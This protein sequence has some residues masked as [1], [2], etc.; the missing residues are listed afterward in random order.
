MLYRNRREKEIRDME[1]AVNDIDQWAKAKL[2]L[3][4]ARTKAPSLLI[5]SGVLIQ[6]PNELTRVMN[7]NPKPELVPSS[8]SPLLPFYVMFFTST[9]NINKLECF[10][11]PFLRTRSHDGSAHTFR[12][13]LQFLE[14]LQKGVLKNDFLAFFNHFF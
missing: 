4:W 6:S 14:V 11:I 7:Q 8:P 5:D 10:L 2:N 1:S 3:G 12:L 9:S 13:S